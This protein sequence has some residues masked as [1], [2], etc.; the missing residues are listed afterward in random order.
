VTGKSNSAIFVK[1]LLRQNFCLALLTTALSLPEKLK[2]ETRL[3]HTRL[4]GHPSLQHLMS[5]ELTVAGYARILKVFYGF[6]APLEKQFSRFPE[7]VDFLPDL[8]SRRKSNALLQDYRQ[9]PY[10]AHQVPPLCDKLPPV[11]NPAQAFGCLYVMEG[12]TLGGRFIANRV[13][14]TLG[15]TIQPALSFFTGYGEQTGHNWKVF[16][17]ALINYSNATQA[18][19]EVVRSANATFQ[20]FYDWMNTRQHG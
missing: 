1:A 20:L 10:V 5:A 2:T 9:L 16:R 17:E 13:S 4:E 8:P 18:D 7:L 11:T 3:L 19:D 14:H 6:F 15:E 12:S